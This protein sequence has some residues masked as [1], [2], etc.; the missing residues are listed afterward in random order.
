VEV[1]A[2]GEN[3]RDSISILMEQSRRIA[4]VGGGISGLAAA[5]ELATRHPDVAFNLYEASG[6]LGG[7][8]ETV[9][10]RGFTIE[11][12]PDS[13]VTEKPWARELAEELGLA[14]EVIA[15]NDDQRR[16]YI[17]Q[18]R[19]LVPMPD[20]MRMMV[21]ARWEPLVHSPLLSWQAKQA[22]LRE[23]K[24]AAELKA[25]A[26]LRRGGDADESVAD[27][28]VRHFGEEATRML[29]G[30]LLAGVFGG[31]IHKLS[32]RAVMMPFVKMEAESGSLIEAIRA[33]ASEA[34][35][36]PATFTSLKGGLESLIDRMVAAIPAASIRR[37]AAVASIAQQAPA[38]RVATETGESSEYDS[39]LLATPAHVTR[40]LLARMNEPIAEQIAAL[41]PME[42]SSAIVVALGF[43]PEK[44]ARLRIP[45]GFGFL[46][47]ESSSETSLL[48]ATFVD[49]KFKHRVP[50]DGV[51][52]R[53][54]FGGRAAEHL[55]DQDDAGL[56]A[57]TRRQLSLLLG[58]LPEPDVA[59]VRHWPHSLPQY[60]VGHVARIARADELVKQ[61]P[62]LSLIGNA[63]HGVGL[64][65]LVRDA[66]AA[67]RSCV[68]AGAATAR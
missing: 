40:V 31:D 39:V 62:G 47:P 55:R 8:V 7:I 35:T 10:E 23:P 22:Y 50:D 44:A 59:V 53:G 52:L 5:H 17:V 13:W 4:I 11:C 1:S 26:L 21:P 67:A 41:L 3:H 14:E 48:A 25:S 30:P 37:K 43:L 12:G 32:V 42:A 16:T 28:V 20:G 57:E 27:F 63:Y 18:G 54:F 33:K 38:W 64:P 46:A 6:R 29:A 9:Q 56:I 51:L 65:D 60:F 68:S 2:L 66:R 34:K 36:K 19:S 15:S 61:L 58:P 24:R 49:Q 45:R